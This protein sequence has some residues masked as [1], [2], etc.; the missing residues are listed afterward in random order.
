MFGPVK[1]VGERHVLRVTLL[2]TGTST[3][4]P[5][6][7]CGCRVCRSEDP[8]DRR[9]RCAAPVEVWSS[10][11]GEN[12]GEDAEPALSVLIDAGPDVRRQ[13]LR[14]G[15]RRL[16]AV[17]L[18]HP[19]FDHIGGLDDLRPFFFENDAP[20]PVYAEA[21]TAHVLRRA[22]PYVFV[23]DSYAAA[24]RL[25]LREIRASGPALAPLHVPSRY[26]TGAALHVRPLRVF[27]GEEP[28]CGYRLGRFSYLTDTSRIP[29]A[30]FAQLGGL[31]VL[32]LDALRRRPHATHFS[33]EE[34]A[35]AARRIG[36][37][38]TYFIHLTHDVLHAEAN[39]GL[40]P[41]IQLG[42]DGLSFDFGV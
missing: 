5:V 39:A 12:P 25:E 1:H 26:S 8:R 22:L 20:L 18:T 16:D 32:V 17:L 34:A 42:Y 31:D 2:G 41:G 40:P 10:G 38:Q 14:H 23:N 29:E 6:I 28:I 13:A 4:V 37:R 35:R 19:H 15:L 7:G 36:A 33:L 30:T 27:H 21:P 3:G 9:L 11:A 24:P